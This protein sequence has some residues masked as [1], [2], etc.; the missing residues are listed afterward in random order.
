MLV[1]LINFLIVL[2]ILGVIYWRT[3]L[4]PL[5]GPLSLII[6][7]VFVLAIVLDLVNVLLS[8]TGTGGLGPLWR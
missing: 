2:L 8:L 7:V 3:T 4:F 1:L 5:P 6:R